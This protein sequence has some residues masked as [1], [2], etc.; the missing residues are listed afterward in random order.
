[1]KGV[2]RVIGF[3]RGYD[4]AVRTGRLSQQDAAVRL[5]GGLGTCSKPGTRDDGGTDE[6]TNSHW[7]LLPDG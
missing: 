4:H 3:E 7:L 5:G 6:D 2:N 1:L